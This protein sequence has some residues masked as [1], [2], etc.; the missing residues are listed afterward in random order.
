MKIFGKDKKQVD[1]KTVLNV[2]YREIL[3]LPVNDFVYYKQLGK[4]LK[5]DNGGLP[6]VE[7]WNFGKVKELQYIMR[8]SVVYEQVPNILAFV[9]ENTKPGY[10]FSQKWYKTIAKYNHVLKEMEKIV[11]KEKALEYEPDADQISAGIENFA[12]FGPFATIDSL[13]DGNVLLYDEIEAKPYNLIFTKLLHERVK[14]EYINNLTA[15][16]SKKRR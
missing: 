6:D 3:D 1:Q 8:E 16:K 13:A 7:L 14:S 4:S 12:Q 10:H 2:S 15:I 5:P 9:Y 11:E